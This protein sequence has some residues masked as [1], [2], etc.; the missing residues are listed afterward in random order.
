MV[1]SFGELVRFDAQKKSFGAHLTR[2][3]T[4]K[5]LG[6]RAKCGVREINRT[7]VDRVLEAEFTRKIS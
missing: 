3:T 6:T 2:L 7:L 4:G 5:N 1:D